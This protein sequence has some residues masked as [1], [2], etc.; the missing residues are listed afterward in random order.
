M[1]EQLAENWVEGELRKK[2]I[3]S[4][5]Q[6]LRVGQKQ[7]SVL[8]QFMDA[9]D[10]VGRRDLCRFIL[11]VLKRI[12]EKRSEL[13]GWTESLNTTGLR[14]A[15]RTEIKEAAAAVLLQA[16]RL[17]KWNQQSLTSGYL[18]ENYSQ[19]QL[20]KA[21]WERLEMQPVIDKAIGICREV[22]F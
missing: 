11:H 1:Q 8:G 16:N 7:K 20:W 5:D 13:N 10:A 19:M 2:L 18:D 14:I 22:S 9:A 4:P 6:M 21:D 17:Q 12:L 3:R 15:D